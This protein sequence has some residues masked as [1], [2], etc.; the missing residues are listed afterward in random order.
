LV[1]LKEAVEETGGKPKTHY[2]INPK[3]L[4]K[5]AL[6][7]SAISAKSPSD[8]PFGTNGTGP[9]ARFQAPEGEARDDSEVL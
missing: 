9:S 5:T 4:A 7:A 1:W 6:E 3:L 8:P 2:R